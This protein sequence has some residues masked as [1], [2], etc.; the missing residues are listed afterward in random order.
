MMSRGA[1]A[2][3]RYN[4]VWDVLYGK[5]NRHIL[6]VPFCRHFRT[7]AVARPMGKGEQRD[8]G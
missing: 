3:L 2:E 8:V 1:T 6:V 4:S 5:V 7:I